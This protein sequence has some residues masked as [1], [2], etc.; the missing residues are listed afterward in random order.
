MADSLMG[1]VMAC[2]HALIVALDSRD[3]AAIEAA[4]AA[5]ADCVARVRAK[6]AWHD[7]GVLR[8]QINHALK[9]SDAAAMRVNYLKNWTRQRLDGLASLRG[10]DPSGL[11]SRR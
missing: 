10:Q 6:S 11:Y 1:E 4:S 8:G 2:Q 5:L 7:G 9:Q 3:A